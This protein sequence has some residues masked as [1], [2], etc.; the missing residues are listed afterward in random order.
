LVRVLL[1][2]VHFLGVITHTDTDRDGGAEIF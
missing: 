1:E 2:P